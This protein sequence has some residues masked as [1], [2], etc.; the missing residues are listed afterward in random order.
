MNPEALQLFFR[1]G[2][3]ITILALISVFAVPRESAEFVASV[4][5][6]AIGLALSSLVILVSRLTK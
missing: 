2:I 4:C 5:S 6:L 1:A 3:F